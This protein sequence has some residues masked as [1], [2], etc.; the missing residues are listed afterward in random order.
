[1][2]EFHKETVHLVQKVLQMND[3]A[4]E[5]LIQV[6][7]HVF[8]IS[9]VFGKLPHMHEKI[10]KTL[11]YQSDHILIESLRSYFS[12]EVLTELAKV[13]PHVMLGDEQPILTSDTYLDGLPHQ[14]VVNF[15][16]K[17]I[18]NAREN[19]QPL[20]NIIQNIPKSH[21]L[22]FMNKRALEICEDYSV[23][24]TEEQ[25]QWLLDYALQNE[26]IQNTSVFYWR[27]YEFKNYIVQAFPHG[28]VPLKCAN[29]NVE[30]PESFKLAP[31]I[32]QVK[33]LKCLCDNIKCFG[34]IHKSWID[35]F[36]EL[37][38]SVI[39]DIPFIKLY[40]NFYKKNIKHLFNGTESNHQIQMLIN[41][42]KKRHS[43]HCMLLIDLK[44]KDSI[45][46]LRNMILQNDAI[47]CDTEV[48]LFVQ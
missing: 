18:N 29:L 9:V 22:M 13:S 44:N 28:D 17:M 11:N 39:K 27:F 36:D 34:E 45:L 20:S 8:Y 1:M 33:I 24:A 46:E 30:A 47:Q 5:D 32:E 41:I 16:L 15:I 26:S 14:K 40:R 23:Y 10:F 3:A 42:L 12:R 21:F 7:R 4:L 43:E 37:P 6:D 19:N 35:I 2:R 48:P 25:K 31:P 38:Y